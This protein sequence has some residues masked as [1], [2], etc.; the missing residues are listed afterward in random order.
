MQLEYFISGE[1]NRETILFVHG[2]GA[3]FKPYNLWYHR[4]N[5]FACLVS[6]KAPG[7]LLILMRLLSLTRFC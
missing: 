2:A 1:S 5:D 4:T 6:S 3:L 7:I